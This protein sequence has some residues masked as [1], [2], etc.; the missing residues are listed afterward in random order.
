MYNLCCIFQLPNIT[1]HYTIIRDIIQLSEI[2]LGDYGY[3]KDSYGYL[4]SMFIWDYIY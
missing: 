4:G 1:L 2:D 3:E